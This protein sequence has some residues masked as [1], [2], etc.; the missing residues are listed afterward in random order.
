MKQKL[1][2]GGLLKV[3]E[4]EKIYIFQQNIKRLKAEEIKK[5]DLVNV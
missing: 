2:S 3:L 1:N 4:V 5:D